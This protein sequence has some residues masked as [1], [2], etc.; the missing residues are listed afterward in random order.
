[1]L[2]KFSTIL[3][4]AGPDGQP[5]RAING[6][7]AREKLWFEPKIQLADGLERTVAWWRRERA[8]GRLP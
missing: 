1:M 4:T 6:S 8:A 7:R 3:V 2:D 5:R